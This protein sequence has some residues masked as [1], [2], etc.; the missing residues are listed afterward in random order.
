MIIVLM[1]KL[2]LISLNSAMAFI[3]FIQGIFAIVSSRYACHALCGKGNNKKVR[4]RA[5]FHQA[6]SLL[7]ISN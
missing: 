5:I 1:L 6:L 2:Q 3:G 4:R 7:C